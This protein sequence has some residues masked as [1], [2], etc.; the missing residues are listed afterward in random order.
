[1]SFFRGF[2]E[3][4]IRGNVVDMG[5]GVIIGAAFG[6]IV[7]SF[8]SDVLMP[9]IGLLL[10]KVN[11]SN[12]YINLSGEH[13]SSLAE[14]QEAGAA[15]VNYGAFIETVIHF[16]IIAFAAY[17][18]I[19]QMNK[20]RRVPMESTKQKSCPYCFSDI[21]SRALRC[22]NCTSIIEERRKNASKRKEA[23]VRISS[24]K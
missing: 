16:V 5:I 11:F 20:L 24:R 3:F 15:T 13:Y 7:T 21:P 14:A 8:V 4:A 2:R 23:V 18:I 19:I 1:M 10:G 12:L 9:P 22:P 17:L 6:G